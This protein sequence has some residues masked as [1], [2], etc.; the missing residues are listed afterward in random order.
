MKSVFIFAVSLIITIS[1]I[2]QEKLTTKSG[3]LKFA[4]STENFEPVEA[5]NKTVSAILKED[6]TLA[7]LGLP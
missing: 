2:A 1:S 5:T 4:A 3:V 6:G 7:V